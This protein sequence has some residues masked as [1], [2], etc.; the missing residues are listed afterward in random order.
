[1]NFQFTDPLAGQLFHV[2]RLRLETI[3]VNEDG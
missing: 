3:V 1:M 2:R